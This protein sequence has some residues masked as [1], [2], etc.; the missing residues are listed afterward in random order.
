MKFFFKLFSIIFIFISI[1]LFLDSFKLIEPNITACKNKDNEN[2]GK[3]MQDTATDMTGSE[4]E[5]EDASRKT[6][7]GIDNIG[8]PPPSQ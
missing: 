2:L 5:T 8:Q 1:I 7:E 6:A 3:E 4:E